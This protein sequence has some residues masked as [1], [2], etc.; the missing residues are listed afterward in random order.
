MSFVHLHVHTQ[1]S[2][3][4]GANK[5]D[6]L[7]GKVKAAGMPAVAMTDHGNMFGAVEF[8]RKA[9]AAGIK[10]IL[11]C[12][13]YVAPRSRRDRGGRAD[14]FEAGGNHHLILLVA[15]AEGYRNLCRL[16]TLGYKEGFYYKPRVDKELLR[17]LNGGLIALS[18]CLAS[19]VNQ[20]IAMGSID[21][22]RE[23]MREYQ[24]MFDGRYYV[25]VQDNHLPQQERANAELVRLARELGL[26][27]V[28]TNDCHYLE[29]DDA[30][31][32]EVLLCI[33]TG[34]TFSDPKRWRFET[35]QL[36]VKDPETMRAAFPD[37]PEALDNTLDVARRCDFELTFGKYQFPVFAT[38]AGETLESHLQRTAREG[39]ERRLTRLRSGPEWTA[40]REAAYRERLEAELEI[41]A[42]MGF[43]GYLL[44]VADFTTYAKGQGIPVGPGRGSAAGSL[45]A[46]AL[47]ITDL[48]PIPYNLLFERFLNPERK[49]MP[50]IDMDFCFERRDEVI[51]YVR[52]KYG[53]DRV[54]QIITFGTLKGKQA[55]K[56]VGRVLDFSFGDTDRIAKLYPAAK[57]GKDFPLQ[58]ALEMEPR[59]QE[60][61]R[62]GEREQQLFDHALRLEGLLRHA[63]KH[64]A[65]IVIGERPL[66]ECLP[67]F[68]DK[69]NSVMTQ[70]PYGDVDAIGLIKFDFLGLKTLTMIHNVVR[71]IDGGRGVKLDVTTLPLDDRETYRLVAKGD[72]VG[73]FQLE[74]GGMRKLLTQLRPSTF[75]DII[76]VLALF[77]PGPL[78]SGM[79]EEFIKRKHGKEP[80]AY[81]HPALEPILRDTYG[82]IVYQE[83]VMQIAQALGGYSLGDADNLRRAMGKKKKDEME[84]EK[85]R[86]LEGARGRVPEKLAAEIFNQMETFAAYGFNKS[87]S[88]A[89][90]LVSYQ[91]AYLK[92]HF[93]E[94]FMAGLLTLEMND[95]DKIYKNIAECRER[96]IPIL[97][98]D[99]NESYQDF[100]V[101]AADDGKRRPIRFGLG[102]VRGVGAKAIEAIVAAR[103]EGRFA[104]LPDFCK[105]VIGAQV[106]KRVIESLIKSGAFDFTGEPR[107]RLLEGLERIC[108][109]AG[110]SSRPVCENQ[111]SLFVAAGLKEVAAPPPALPEVE[112]WDARERLRAEREAIGFFITGHPLDK[113][114]RDL[115]R[116]ADATTDSLRTRTNQSAVK[117]GGVVHTLKLKNSRKGDRYATFNLEDR[118]GVVEVIAWPE[119]YRR[120]EAVIHADEPVLVTGTLEASED[121]CQ[122]IADEVEGLTAAREK[123][124]RQVHI[125]LRCERVDDSALR[126]LR[127]TLSEHRGSCNAFLHLL[128]PNRTETVIA[129]PADLKV[130]PTERMVEAVEQLFGSGVTSF[131]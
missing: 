19:E 121:R 24:A 60:V 5:I 99:V 127:R 93:P 77:R 84:R 46:Y 107:R 81:L 4:D 10:P 71:R 82:V 113:Y 90:A 30:R 18:G 118:L 80:I 94:E 25:E 109:W 95:T 7:I 12:E 59:L 120:C 44:I 85:V 102:A 65:G 21:R 83:Q 108:Q 33:Q 63:S 40:E 41:V 2:L 110:P 53:D 106:N 74:S 123:S 50:D 98:P 129:L 55:I 31:A 54:A 87:H 78:D 37:C 119:V 126:T 39:L 117:L 26:P 86:F 42:S 125:A 124:V 105:R 23:V 29:P 16:V 8:Y 35:D 36:Y 6:A 57:Q 58:E 76:A 49:S 3:L 72:T 11:G 52:E 104:S 43:A 131:Q 13:V 45:V 73:V 22:A 61:R 68:V 20:A 14:D 75:E 89:Y 48:D 51:R 9:S 38:P 92:A 32:H 115:K 28:A 111:I 62:R 128:L 27:L 88:A 64:A 69:D 67:L 97:P 130:A 56:D 17:E 70:F 112:E 15:N 101:V 100:T 122:L 1:Y 34:K 79:V 116:I 47:G 103:A 114:E 96:A 66:V 91:T